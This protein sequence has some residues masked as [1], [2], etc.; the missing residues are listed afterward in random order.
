MTVQYCLVLN[1]H[2]F[3]SY[4][5]YISFIVVAMTIIVHRPNFHQ[6][7]KV[8][9]HKIEWELLNLQNSDMNILLHD[10]QI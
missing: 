9:T 8:L 3:K 2:L 10:K 1:L 6:L 5:S 4:N 7:H